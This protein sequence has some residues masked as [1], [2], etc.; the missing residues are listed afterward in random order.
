MNYLLSIIIPTK[1]RHNYL[2]YCIESLEQLDTKL[3]EI[4]IQDNSDNNEEFVKFLKSKNYKNVKYFYVAD[5]TISQTEN[6]EL[7]LEKTTGEY[8]C[9]IGDDDSIT[10]WILDVVHWMK[11]NKSEGVIFSPA[12]YSWPDLEYRVFK[13]PNLIIPTVDSKYIQLNPQ[14]ELHKCLHEGGQIGNLPKIYHGVISK[15]TLE[16]VKSKFGSYFPGASPDMA[17]AVALSA[18]MKKY[19]KLKLPIVISGTCYYSAGGMGARGQHKDQLSNVQ[20]LPKNISD[21]WINKIPKIWTGESIWAHSCLEALY[22]IGNDELLR[23]FNYSKLYARMIVM[24]KDC[25]NYVKPCIKKEKKYIV[26]M[27]YMLELFLK[28]A[29][30]Y[31]KNYFSLNFKINV[32]TSFNDINNV[33]DASD[34]VTNYIKNLELEIFK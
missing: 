34:I 18:V 6:S 12:S 21:K 26:T 4:I 31:I 23:K 15:S 17:N 16:K 24:H 13:F 10:P 29:I 30:K 28:R 22:K 19:H 25:L 8:V 11:I 2:R 20:Q 5:N 7:A 9:F 27:L 3:T 32:N 1:N 33:R 14:H